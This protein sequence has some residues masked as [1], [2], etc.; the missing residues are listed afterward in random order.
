MAAAN[1]LG[2][3]GY[4]GPELASPLVRKFAAWKSQHAQLDVLRL[5]YLQAQAML[6][7]ARVFDECRSG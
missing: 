5:P 2:R 7:M 6:L 1:A 3:E 4:V